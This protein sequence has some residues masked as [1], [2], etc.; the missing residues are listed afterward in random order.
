MPPVYLERDASKVSICLG[1]AS[2]APSALICVKYG[3]FL[4]DTEELG[5][6]AILLCT[7]T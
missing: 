7:A 4:F 6:K 5:E 2:T 1:S 3:K